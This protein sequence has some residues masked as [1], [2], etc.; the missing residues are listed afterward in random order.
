MNNMNDLIFCKYGNLSNFWGELYAVGFLRIQ[1]K[2]EIEKSA[3]KS[4]GKGY[5]MY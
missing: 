5:L 3:A 2:I 4:K 1:T